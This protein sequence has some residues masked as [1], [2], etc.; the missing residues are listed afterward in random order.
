MTR[1][2]YIKESLARFEE[3]LRQQLERTDR[4]AL[5]P[6]AKD[7]GRL[8]QVTI[9]LVGGDGIGPIIMKEA[10]RVLEKLLADE[11]N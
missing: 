6:P 5:A 11:M 4:L 8:E 2:D 10:R 7:F 3:L 9:G 1:E